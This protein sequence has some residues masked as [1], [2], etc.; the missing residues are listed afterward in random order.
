MASINVQPI[1]DPSGEA[2]CFLLEVEEATI[3]LDVGCDDKLVRACS[4]PS[5]G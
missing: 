2:R 5:P 3:L 1:G 4:T